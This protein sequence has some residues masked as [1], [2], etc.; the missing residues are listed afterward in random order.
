MKNYVIIDEEAIQKRIEEM[1]EEY[2]S[3]PA[4]QFNT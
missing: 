4:Y 3:E 2:K 1:E